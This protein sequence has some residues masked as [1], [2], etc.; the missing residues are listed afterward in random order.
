MV[1]LV[2]SRIVG[3]DIQAA[4]ITRWKFKFWKGGVGGERRHIGRES[5]SFSSRQQQH[6]RK[7]RSEMPA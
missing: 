4:M 5:R 2:T 7:L 1:M 6:Q 3:L